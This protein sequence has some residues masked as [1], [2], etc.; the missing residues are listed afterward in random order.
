[1]KEWDRAEWELAKSKEELI[2]W[3]HR[4][5]ATVQLEADNWSKSLREIGRWQN[6]ALEQLGLPL[7]Y[8]KGNEMVFK[9]AFQMEELRQRITNNMKRL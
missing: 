2:A 5:E 1:M 6:W 4:L 8:P 9:N 3:I 7:E